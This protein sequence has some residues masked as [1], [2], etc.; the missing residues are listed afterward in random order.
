MIH[1]QFRIRLP[2][3]TWIADV[4]RAYP[5]ATFELL[6]GMPTDD[7]AVELGAVSG[8]DV[9]A[10]V[11]AIRDH[12]AITSYE[13]LDA[14]SGRVL[15]RYETTDRALYEFAAGPSLTPEFPVVVQNGWF[16]FELTGTRQTFDRF[17]STLEEG[18][19]D[20]EL[21]S[22]VGSDSP[23]NRL[24]DRQQEVLEAAVR[25]GYF[26]VPRECTLAELAAELDVDKSTASGI[27]RRAEERIVKPFVLGVE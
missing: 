2:D 21:L 14:E 8:S 15:G 18:D 26:D 25:M 1:A 16:E 12:D 20:Y 13:K 11:D 24:T 22:L 7:G 9:D 27:V 4:S 3:E 17:R 23:S 19:V 5:D 6:S 10:A